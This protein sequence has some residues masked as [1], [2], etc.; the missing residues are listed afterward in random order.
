LGYEMLKRFVD[1]IATRLDA[2]RLQLEDIY[3]V[4]S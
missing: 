1:L 2:T 3:A 4:H